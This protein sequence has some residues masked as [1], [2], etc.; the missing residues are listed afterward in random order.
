M[1]PGERICELVDQ[2]QASI[3]LAENAPGEYERT[4][5]LP[6]DP[7]IDKLRATVASL[8]AQLRVAQEQLVQLESRPDP[9]QELLSNALI[10][11]MDTERIATNL[12]EALTEREVFKKFK[13]RKE[14][15]DKGVW[16]TMAARWARPLAN[17][18][19]FQGLSR[20][21]NLKNLPALPILNSIHRSAKALA[22]IK[23]VL[24]K[25]KLNND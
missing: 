3:L 9:R 8:A 11:E 18:A 4:K 1:E 7:A 23:E 10:L 24:D 12:H 6:P 19:R 2:L 5:D 15:C 14:Q 25:E 13:V 17:Y 20:S 22:T 16:R 21:L